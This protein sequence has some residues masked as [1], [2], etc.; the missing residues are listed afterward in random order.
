MASPDVLD[1]E[2]LLSLIS[3]ESPAGDEFRLADRA[4]YSE[5]RRMRDILTKAEKTGEPPEDDEAKWERVFEMS[6][7][8]L[9][10]VSKDLT[11]AAWLVEAT[12][13]LHGFAGLRDGARL[14]RELLGSFWDSVHPRPDE[15][16]LETTMQPLVGLDATL[17]A[18][19]ANV[20]VTAGSS[21]GPYAL[22]QYRQ[23]TELEQCDSEK[24][25]QRL[26]DG[27]ISREDFDTSVAESSPDFFRGILDDMAQ[28][29]TE[30]QTL[31][32]FLDDRCETDNDGYPIAPSTSHIRETVEDAIRTVRGL[33]KDII[34]EDEESTGELSEADG[35]PAQTTVKVGPGGI[36][37]REDAF[38]LLLDVA[39]FF[40]RTEPHSPVS[41]AVEQVVRWGR[42]SLPE[43]LTDLVSDSSARETL[44]RQVG[45]PQVNDDD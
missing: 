37:S 13:R 24:R 20:P 43:L 29:L 18:P 5:I 15:D 34:G 1:F 7:R 39:R 33:A 25:Q 36:A 22:W 31:D 23:A 30:L 6:E 14:V 26:A 45:I 42:M 27:W 11:V 10:E 35:S 41:Y 19:L 32:T 4:A 28:S 38:N 16:G 40:K 21:A 2:R 9:A 8:T 3:E 44:F 17:P 12:I